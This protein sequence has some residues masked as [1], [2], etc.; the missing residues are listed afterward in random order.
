MSR[1]PRLVLVVV[2]AAVAH[3]LDALSFSAPFEDVSAG[4]DRVVGRSWRASGSAAVHAN[5]VRLTPDRQSK[6][7]ALWAT[8][9]AGVDEVSATLKFRISGQ[10]KKYYGD[11][12][13]LWLTDARA[14][15]AGDFH[16]SAETFRGV[17]VVFDT[18]KNA[19]TLS[20]HKD[21]AVVVN[22]GTRDAEALLADASGCAGD[23]RYHEA[24]ADFSVA[25]A[26]RARVVVGRRADG[27]ALEAV[28]SLDARNVGA[29]VECAR[30]ALP[31]ALDA[32]W[33]RRAHLGVTASTG[34]LADNHDVLALDVS[35]DAAEHAAADA[36]GARAAPF[37]APGEGIT[38]DRFARIEA[39]LDALVARLEH[40]QHHL[41]HEMVA[42][43]DHVRVTL[44]KLARQED[45]SEGRIDA[46]ERKVVSNVEDSLSQR[47]ASL[48]QAMRDAVQKRIST[49]ENRYMSR[50][51]DVV[52]EKVDGAGR[53]WT[54][55]FVFLVVVDV[56]AFALARAWYLKFRKTHL[57]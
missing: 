12:L 6:R 30:V 38:A 45:S 50:L 23:V 31:A 5:F 9:A 33:L 13:A 27:D 53:G 22:D 29:F 1:L 37:F 36:D 41:E 17:G 52:S 54:L 47:I 43:D 32:A 39:Q 28:V 42:V 44:E 18:F 57:L 26:S 56:V 19:E 48:E 49:V 40:L 55:P 21:V 4:G 11:G 7:G 51:G 8:A 35:S 34:Q 2:P 24:R 3:V 14:H 15:R 25:S 46:L 10:G 20:L 16:G